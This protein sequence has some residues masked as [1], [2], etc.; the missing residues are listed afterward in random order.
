MEHRFTFEQS[1]GG[2]L[3]LTGVF[4]TDLLHGLGLTWRAVHTENYN[5][6]YRDNCVTAVS[7]A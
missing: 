3:V 4:L 6:N 2:C 7:A 5:Y 1:G